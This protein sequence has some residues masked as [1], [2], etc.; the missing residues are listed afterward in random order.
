MYELLSRPEK[1]LATTL[2]GTNIA[3]V[4]SSSL[5]T[6]LLIS[7]G[8]INS[9]VWVTFLFTP[10]VVIFAELIP[11]NIGRHYREEFTIKFATLFV[12]F[13]RLL[14]PLVFA[15]EKISLIAIKLFL[16]KAKRPFFITRE[17]IKALIAEVEKEGVLEKG[18]KEAIEEIFEFGETK[19]KDVSIPLSNVVGVDYA[20]SVEDIL[21]VARMHGFTRYP[22]FRNRQIVGYL[23]IFDLF[24]TKDTQWQKAI[25]PITR[26]G[27]SQK[28]YDIF[29]VLQDKKET[30]AV[31]LKGNKVLGIVTQE[32]LMKEILHSIVK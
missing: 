12:F 6:S 17:G 28:L 21:L 23:T 4:V 8:I 30:I 3:V 15:A 5:A 13:E 20:D 32:D 29:T 31:V 10:L 14:R 2:L 1:F 22:V 24:Y 11:K 16:G 27:A 25:R 9:A 7:L 19:I 26:V 18:E